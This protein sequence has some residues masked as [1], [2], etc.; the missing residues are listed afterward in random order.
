MDCHHGMELH[1]AGATIHH[2][3][4]SYLLLILLK[5]TIL[6]RIIRGNFFKSH[7]STPFPE[8]MIIL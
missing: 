2:I 7:H 3:A 8:C 5:M 4:L 6:H 1:K